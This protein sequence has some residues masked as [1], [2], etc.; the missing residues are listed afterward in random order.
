MVIKTDLPPLIRTITTPIVTIPAGYIKFSGPFANK[1]RM[2]IVKSRIILPTATIPGAGSWVRISVK[3]MNVIPAYQ[4]G[5]S[6]SEYYL[7]MF[8]AGSPYFYE[9]CSAYTVDQN[10]QFTWESNF[11]NPCP[12]QAQVDFIPITDIRDGEG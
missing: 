11:I 9:F 12:I 10:E 2:V 3:G 7:P 5:G 6:S 8:A 1:V 4:Y